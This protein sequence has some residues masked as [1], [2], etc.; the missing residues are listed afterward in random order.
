MSSSAPRI[1]YVL[2]IYN[3]ASALDHLFATLIPAIEEIEPRWELVCVDDGSR[4]DSLARLRAAAAAEPRIRVEALPANRGKGAAVR[5]GM[6]RAS[7]ALRI[8]MDADLSTDLAALRPMISALEGDADVVVGNRRAA[9]S[10][11]TERQPWVREL[12]G[13][14]FQ[15]VAS[16]AFAPGIEDLTCGFKGFRATAVEAVFSRTHIDRWAFDVEVVLIAHLLGFTIEQ[17]EVRWAHRE[18]SKV[19]VLRAVLSSLRDCSRILLYRLLRRY[20]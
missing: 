18:N 19:R 9:R 7:G 17:V 11:I 6:L 20:R 13:R 8:F 1:S 16:R 5:M 12:L 10:A 15:W 3:E 2:P 4:D 14:G